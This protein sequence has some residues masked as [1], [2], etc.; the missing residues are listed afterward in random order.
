MAKRLSFQQ[1]QIL[2]RLNYSPCSASDF[3]RLYIGCNLY[4]SLSTL[5]NKGLITGNKKYYL[6]EK[7]KIVLELFG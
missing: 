2:K 3:G 1:I 5:K 6:T 7:G 4:R